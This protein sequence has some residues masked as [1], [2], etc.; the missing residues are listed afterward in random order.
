MTPTLRT[1]I[2]AA[3]YHADRVGHGDAPSLSSSVARTLIQQ[4]PIHAW[5][6]HPKLG[7]APRESTASMSGLASTSHFGGVAVGVHM[8][9]FRPAAP[10]VSTARS[11]H[12]QSNLPGSGSIRLQANSP[13]RTHV[14]PR[15]AIRLASSAHISSGQCSG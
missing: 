1:D 9:I 7:N 3:D 4:S 6:K 10:R 15:S 8:T 11:S 12:D 13:I 5:F 14:R 2:P